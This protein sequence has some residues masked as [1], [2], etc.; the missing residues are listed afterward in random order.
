MGMVSLAELEMIRKIAEQKIKESVGFDMN[1]GS[2]LP[3]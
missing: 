1:A 3:F 2:D